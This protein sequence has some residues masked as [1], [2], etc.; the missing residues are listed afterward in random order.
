MKTQISAGFVPPR[1]ARYLYR[2]SL[3][4]A[5]ALLIAPLLVAC[6]QGSQPK[7]QESGS[8]A[9]LPPDPQDPVVAKVDGI[10]IRESDLAIAQE[11]FGQNAPALT[12]DAKR[13]YLIAYLS[14]IILVAR[15]AESK[16]LGETADFQRRLRF[17]R[18]KLLAEARLQDEIK[19]AVTEEAMRSVYNE[20]IKGM[21]TNEEEVR[22]RH[23]LIR[24][25]D[26]KDE[27]ASR[28]AENKIKALIERLKKG[29]D[30]AALA[31]EFTEDP[32]GKQNG[33]D[34]DYFTKDQMVPEFSAAA[35]RLEKGQIS[36][37][38]RTQFG[39]HVLKVEDKRIRQPPQYEQVKDQLRNI[40]VRKAQAE[41]I[42]K[43]RADAKIERT[44]RPV[45]TKPGESK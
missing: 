1:R 9:N 15:A 13:E 23:I 29:E 37:P 16:K 34:L 24:V 30:F 31:N 19:S 2:L 41:L 44:D 18:H 40:V 39:W 14:D 21:N 32:S 42:G 26:P 11:D 7:M 17:T 43:L 33:G 36:E 12:Q 22:A 27:K 6:G 3:T 28:E 35:F 45:E 20:A 38:V 8:V 4:A 5:A 10:E 25:T